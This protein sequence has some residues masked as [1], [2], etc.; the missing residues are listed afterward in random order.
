MIFLDVIHRYNAA[1]Y[2]W[3]KTAARILHDTVVRSERNGDVTVSWQAGDRWIHTP[4]HVFTHAE[5][6]R[7]FRSAGLRPIQR[8]VIRYDTGTVCRLPFA[9]QL[10]YQLVPSSASESQTNAI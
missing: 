1:A 8:W 10:L 5:M 4:S 2:G 6:M 9:G 7:L 3:T